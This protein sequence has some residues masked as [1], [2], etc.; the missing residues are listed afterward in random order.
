M[1]ITVKASDKALDPTLTLASPNAEHIYC[2]LYNWLYNGYALTILFTLS[3]S[4]ALA[5]SLT[6]TCTGELTLLLAMPLFMALQCIGYFIDYAIGHT[7]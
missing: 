2:L 4:M 5:M 1:A 6:L 3:L 7:I